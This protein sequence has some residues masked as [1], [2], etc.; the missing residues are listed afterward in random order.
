MKKRGIVIELIVL[1]LFFFSCTNLWAAPNYITLQG[2]LKDTAGQPLSGPVDLFIRVLDG[3][4]PDTAAEEYSEEHLNVVLINGVYNVILG[5]GTNQIGLFDK[6]L[7]NDDSRFLQI[8]I[9]QAP[10]SD[11]ELLTPPQPFNSVAYALNAG[12]VDGLDST[13]F[14]SST[15][16]TLAGDIIVNG[17]VTIANGTQGA[18]KVLSSDAFGLVTWELPTIDS[19]SEGRYTE[20]NSLFLGTNAGQNDDGG[21]NRNVGIGYRVL[22]ENRSGERNT[23]IGYTA[24]QRNITGGN[25]NT[26]FGSSA[27]SYNT[28]GLSNT[29]I[30][31]SALVMNTTGRDNT[32]S[33]ATALME[34]ETGDYNTANGGGALFNNIDGDRNTAIGYH[35][36]YNHTTGWGNVAIGNNADLNNGSG[37]K[38]TIIGTSAGSSSPANNQSGN[39]FI[40]Y[41]A[42]GNESGSDKLYIEN[43]N[44]VTPLIYGD[45]TYGSELV[46]IHGDFETTGQ[47]KN[48]RW[49]SGSREGADF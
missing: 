47:V 29:A 40:G 18:G 35:S 13:A 28:T 12:S 39:V 21:I 22:E 3:I 25:G 14:F 44:S 20:G 15:G 49:D 46:R 5:G 37:I 1:G 36:L 33:G 24:L 32:A 23:A 6:V 2:V 27:L 34:N 45:F 17:H 48:C 7:F 38:N 30:G 9:R 31:S 11:Y 16:G 10:E 41:A 19:F 42:G 8:G 4:D 26:A 43:S